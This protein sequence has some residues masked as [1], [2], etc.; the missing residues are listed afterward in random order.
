MKRYKSLFK[1]D[2]TE[3]NN[4]DFVYQE[5]KFKKQ[6]SKEL[7]LPY[8]GKWANQNKELPIYFDDADMVSMLDDKT[9]F[10]NA[11]NGKHTYGELK[12]FVI[13]FMKKNT[14]NLI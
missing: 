1:E 2:S 10:K 8:T 9:I 11:I 3:F 13:N 4:D 7:K 6:L 14:P 12:T 5:L